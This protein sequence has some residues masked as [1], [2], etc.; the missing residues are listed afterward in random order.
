MHVFVTSSL[1][2]SMTKDIENWNLPIK[3]DL[4]LIKQCLF[5]ALTKR[6]GKQ[7]MKIEELL[8]LKIC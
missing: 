3:R 7:I 2:V 6:E 4:L 1:M 8:R 5:S